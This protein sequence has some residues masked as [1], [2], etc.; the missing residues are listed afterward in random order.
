LI[1]EKCWDEDGKECECS[2]NSWEGC[3]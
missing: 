2:E 3:K 1:S